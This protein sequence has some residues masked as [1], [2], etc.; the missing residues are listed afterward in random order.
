MRAFG[1]WIVVI[2][3]TFAPVGA[4][5]AVEIDSSGDFQNVTPSVPGE[6]YVGQVNGASG[7]YLGDGWV[8]T[9]AHV[10]AG[11]F[12]LNSLT[13]DEVAGS[14]VQLTT[15]GSTVEGTVE[16]TEP[17][18]LTLFRVSGAPTLPSLPAL[19]LATAPPIAY[20]TSLGGG[21]FSNGSSVVIIGYGEG[22]GE[23]YGIDHVTRTN[24]QVDLTD[25]HPTYV[26]YDFVTD[27]GT[28]NTFP[29][30]TFTNSAQLVSGDSGG[31][32]FIQNPVTG[33]YELA[34][35]NEVEFLDN[36]N[37]LVGS[38]F[39]QLSDSYTE[40]IEEIT[41]IPE[42]RAWAMMLSSVLLLLV[43]TR[44]QLRA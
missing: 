17:A 27:D 30:G 32:D 37:N 6:A 40:Q 31:G 8:L 34:G 14:A 38:G 26:S 22:H 9:A 39:V 12:L 42:P 20:G 25:P 33:V 16:P 5:W 24:F 43:L 18:D 15:F 3:G 2:L 36:S 23:T 21:A 13:Y 19:T 11:N 4:A 10:G 1:K 41:G 29:T 28:G 7:V 35:I 44:R